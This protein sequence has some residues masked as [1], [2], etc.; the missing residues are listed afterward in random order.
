MSYFFYSAILSLFTISFPYFHPVLFI[1]LS[2]N[3]FLLLILLFFLLLHHLLILL[4]LLRPHSHLLL[5][6]SHHSSSLPIPTILLSRCIQ[7]ISTLIFSVW[8]STYLLSFL[9][10]PVLF[11]VSSSCVFLFYFTYTLSFL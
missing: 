7:I 3:S 10:K 5:L 8:I 11:L 1:Y 9:F 6:S 2:L 4:L